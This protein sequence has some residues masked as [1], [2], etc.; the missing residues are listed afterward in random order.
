MTG[1][2]LLSLE[3]LAR[4]LRTDHKCWDSDKDD[5]KCLE[6]RLQGAIVWI[7]AIEQV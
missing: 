2:P 1:A 5:A 3:L 4:T 7:S 6:R